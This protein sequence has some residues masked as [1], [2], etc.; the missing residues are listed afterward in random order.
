MI[1]RRKAER[2][3]AGVIENENLPLG[4]GGRTMSNSVI[5][6]HSKYNFF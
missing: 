4:S 3:T 2:R 6:S 1:R 5:D